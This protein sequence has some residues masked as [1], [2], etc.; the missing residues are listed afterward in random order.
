MLLKRAKG[1]IG[2]GENWGFK[3][4]SSCGSV[5]SF[6]QVS[7]Q[8]T[9]LGPWFRGCTWWLGIGPANVYITLYLLSR[10]HLIKAWVCTSQGLT[11]STLT[12]LWVVPSTYHSQEANSNIVNSIPTTVLAGLTTST[13]VRHP[14]WEYLSQ[15][16]EK[17]EPVILEWLCAEGCTRPTQFFV[18]STCSSCI[19]Y[20][21]RA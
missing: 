19:V 16:Y 20:S 10:R 3:S 15:I 6:H 9:L 13:S 2:K 21:I 18:V 4:P 17:L 5:V 12:T 8:L 11:S 7:P 14:V 1:G